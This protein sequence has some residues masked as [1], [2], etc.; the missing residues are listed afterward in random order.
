VLRRRQLTPASVMLSE[1]VAVPVGKA[2]R[3]L[4]PPWFGQ[5]VIAAGRRPQGGSGPTR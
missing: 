2:L 5:S 4:G 3:R 1:R